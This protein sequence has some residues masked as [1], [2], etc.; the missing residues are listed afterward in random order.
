MREAKKE[1]EFEPALPEN[2]STSNEIYK[3]GLF[4]AISPY[5]MQ[6]F[7]MPR[8]RTG[9]HAFRC[10]WMQTSFEAD[11]ASGGVSGRHKTTTV[12]ERLGH[13]AGCRPRL[14]KGLLGAL[15]KP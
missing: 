5:Y 14:N 11:I 10:P 4:E 9:S 7:R 15:G 13:A 2:Q 1:V 12:S 3:L 8:S 6:Y